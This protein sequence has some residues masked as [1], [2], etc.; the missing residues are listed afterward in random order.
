MSS[1][2]SWIKKEI[3]Y[4]KDSFFEIIKALFLVVL[5]SS[6]LG[7]ALILRYLGYNGTIISFVSIIAEIISLLLCYYLLRGYLKTEEKAEISK[8]KGK[9]L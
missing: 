3:V 4:I 6:G 5:A 8:S 1:V 9:K 2:L 7:F